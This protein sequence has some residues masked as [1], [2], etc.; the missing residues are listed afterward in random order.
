M[1]TKSQ[2]T[3]IRVELPELYENGQ[4]DQAEVLQ[5]DLSPYLYTTGEGQY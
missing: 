3:C 1:I 5:G 4:E 2:R